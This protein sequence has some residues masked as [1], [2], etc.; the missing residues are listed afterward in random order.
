MKIL[1]VALADS[2][3]TARWISQISDRGW[4]VRLFPSL[5]HGVVHPDLNLIPVYHTLGGENDSITRKQRWR[6]PRPV[7]AARAFLGMRVL[8]I[9]LPQR[10]VRQLLR[11]IDN[12][13]PDIVH[14]LE[15]QAAG[16]LTA[17][18]K[19]EQTRGFPPWIA[20]NWGSDIYFFRQFPEHEKKIRE[21]L[22][23]CDYYACEC[24]RDV[25]L[26]EVYGFKGQFLPVFPN[27]GGFDL[28]TVAAQCQPGLVSTRRII[29][30][31]GYQHWVGRALV[32]VG[33]LGLCADQLRSYEVVIHSSSP[34]TRQT[35]LAFAKRTGV[36]VT[37]L[38]PD[39]AHHDILKW[40]GQAR[41][42]L[43]LSL[44]DGI[45]T[46]LLEALVMGAFPIQ[47][48]TACADEWIE[49]GKSGLLVPPED[50]ASVAA[51]L[52]RALTDDDLV[53]TAA[54]INWRTAK[55]R[56]DHHL[57]KQK[58]VDLYA[59]VVRDSRRDN[60]PQNTGAGVDLL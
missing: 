26:A 5:D 12:F 38:P 7:R 50:V 40:Y 30:L 45:S 4:D 56:L 8:P 34:A 51:A 46:S 35:A 1:L 11:V 54:V 60:A 24:Q 31:K 36:K 44:S 21:V 16:Y 15:F 43:G 33:A 42:A 28:Q 37:I 20:S 17:K 59:K 39:T 41:V 19:R 47:S 27:A 6:W 58:A 23:Q 22:A 10:R 48:W 2:V 25:C 29:M 3:H 32:G 57:L 9:L 14:S 55:E 13:Q 52:R 53:N 18:V 49:D